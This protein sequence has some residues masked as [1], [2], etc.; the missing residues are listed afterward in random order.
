MPET[1]AEKIAQALRKSALCVG[2]DTDREKLPKPL[3]S[4]LEGVLKFNETIIEATSQYAGAYKIN[5]AFYES[6]GAEGWNILKHTVDSARRR[7]PSILLIADAKRGDIGNTAEHYARAVFEELGFDSITVNAYMGYD[8]VE[9]FIRNPQK[10]AF[11]LCL[12]SNPGSADFQYFSDG[13]IRFYERMALKTVEWNRHD[14]C[15]LV[16][17]ATHAEEMAGLRKIAGHMPFLIPGV[18][19]QGGDLES[20]VRINRQE[21]HSLALINVSRA[22]IYASSDVDYAEA[23]AKKAEYF[24]NQIVSILR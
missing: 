3:R 22:V 21:D 12:T 8:S 4:R 1:F 14:N 15:G 7:D 6:L 19:A 23:A 16:V 20:A 2:L 10:G 13:Q 17:G 9:P 5:F 18:G 24:F 11:L